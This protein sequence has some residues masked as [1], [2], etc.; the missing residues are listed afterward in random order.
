MLIL[1]AVKIC[2][3]T[4]IYG[5]TPVGEGVANGEGGLNLTSYARELSIR[6]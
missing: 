2:K 1:G 5:I 4:N 6:W 3:V